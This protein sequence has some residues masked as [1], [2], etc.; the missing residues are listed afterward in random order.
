MISIITIILFLVYLFGLGYTATYWLKKPES[1]I[2]RILLYL[3]IG[4][5][6]LSFLLIVLNFIHVPLDW[7]IIFTLSVVFPLFLVGK[8]LISKQ[9]AVPTPSWKITKSNLIFGGV[10]LIVGLSLFFYLQGAF[11]YPYLED[12]DPWG[13]AVGVKYV[14]IEKKAYDPLF[15]TDRKIDSVLSY[16][17]PYPPAY[18]A[19]LGILHQTS[20][21]LTW[22]IKFFNVLII[23]LGLLF[24]Y[25][26]VQKF[27]GDNHKALLALFFL[28]AVPA[29]FTHFIWAHS[30]TIALFFPLM[31]ALLSIKDDH[32]WIYVAALVMAGVGVSQNIE[33]PFKITIL[34]ALF[35]IVASI[36]S[37]K[38]LKWE[39]TAVVS[40]LLLSLVWWGAMVQ[41]YT[42]QGLLQYFTGTTASVRE[43]A[44][45]IASGSSWLEKG[46][47][48]FHKFT[49]SGGSGSRAYTLSDFFIA[50][51]SNQINAAI[52]IGL[53]ISLLVLIAVIGI[54]WKYKSSVVAEDNTWLAVTVVW[55]LILLWGVNGQTFP[56]SILRGPFRIWLLLAIPVAI[57]AAE[58]AYF[59]MNFG[60]ALKIPKSIVLI[61]IIIGVIFTSAVPKVEANTSIWPTSGSFLN[62]QEAYEYSVWFN[63]LPPDTKVFLYSPRDKITIGFGKYSCLWCEEVLDF[64]DDII[65]QDAAAIHSFL[66]SQGYEYLVINGRMDSRYFAGIF[67]ENKTALLLPER[68]NEI[69]SSRLFTPVYQKENLFLVFLVN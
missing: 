5:G 24:F 32:H 55:F 65:H 21:D 26:F 47:A 42:V 40:G 20:P 3:A 27:M 69:S 36:T 45:T 2:E 48:V 61:L 19:M 59:L 64:R 17:D 18:D 15:S 51:S 50:S 34:A 39:S 46:L 33:Q 67:G 54:F 53:I 6:I 58:G 29:Y 63:T 22:T 4:L 8:K 52:G 38:F 23:C 66:L 7:K 11:A 49:S 37:R 68:Y 10:L 12:E 16:I 31:Y 62:P 1:Q 9:F 13:H 35:I 60:K 41:R 43:E 44:L 56:V 57:L 30:L 25:L 28:A 14:A